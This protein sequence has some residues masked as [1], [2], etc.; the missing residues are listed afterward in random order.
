MN[1][2]I[3]FFLLLILS[4][5]RHALYLLYTLVRF[6]CC[7]T[8]T[9]FLNSNVIFFWSMSFFFGVSMTFFILK[10]MLE[11]EI[12]LITFLSLYW[13]HFFSHV[14]FERFYTHY[15]FLFFVAINRLCQNWK[16][17]KSVIWLFCFLHI[18]V[19]LYYSAPFMLTLRT[20]QEILFKWIFFY[21][22]VTLH[23]SYLSLDEQYFISIFFNIIEE[24]W[25]EN[26][27]IFFSFCCR[28]IID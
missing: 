23:F 11:W 14:I 10:N 17:K 16:E 9:I 5:H 3:W 1:C 12:L 22:V 21:I 28:E 7:K 6:F 24:K 26:L 2:F 19:F 27:E 25:K 13:F 20:Q 15:L 4:N 18:L 8:Q